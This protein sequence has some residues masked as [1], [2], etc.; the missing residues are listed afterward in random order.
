MNLNN[1]PSINLRGEVIPLL[2]LNE[3]VNL[4]PSI[5]D[6]F[7][8][9][10]KKRLSQTGDSESGIGNKDRIDGE[11]TNPVVIVQIDNIKVGI[12]VDAL[13]W[14]EQI[15]IKPLGGFLTNI[16]VF[17]GACIMGNGSVVLVLDPKELYNVARSNPKLSEDRDNKT[18]A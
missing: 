7:I 4:R 5:L 9:Q 18:A 8:L 16:P 13:Y 11:L 3:V 6:K 2:R 15:M 1:Q 10:E 14:Q 12:L 17:T